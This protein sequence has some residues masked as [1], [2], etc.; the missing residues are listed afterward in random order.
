MTRKCRFGKR[1]REEHFLF[2][3]S[4]TPLNHGSYGASPRAVLE[5]QNNFKALENARPDAF[6]VTE[7]PKLI[8]ESR[9]AIAPLLG[10]SV[11]E[12]VLIPNA[13]TGVN[14]VLRN[15]HFEKGDV[16]VYF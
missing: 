14:T 2:S 5:A 1:M 8:N 11:D 3:P 9:T 12:V 7:I 15:L 16:I 13:T 10:A 6:I 4:Y